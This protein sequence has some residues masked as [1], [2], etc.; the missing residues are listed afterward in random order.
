MDEGSGFAANGRSI[1]EGLDS[2]FDRTHDAMLLIEYSNCE[3]RFVRSNMIHKQLSG[4]TSLQGKTP[5]EVL[6]EELGNKLIGIIMNV[7]H[8]QAGDL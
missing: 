7:Q 8:R 3:F 2:V 1:L 5:V 4:F 6:G